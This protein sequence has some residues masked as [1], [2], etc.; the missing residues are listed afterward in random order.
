LVSRIVTEIERA[1]ELTL[2]R[3]QRE[4]SRGDEL[5]KQINH[6]LLQPELARIPHLRV[7]GSEQTAKAGLTR[8]FGECSELR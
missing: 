1:I 8:K 2:D 5:P 7:T 4:V 6:L 3:R